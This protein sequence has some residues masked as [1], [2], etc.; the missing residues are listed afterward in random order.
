MSLQKSVMLIISVTTPTVSPPDFMGD[1]DRSVAGEQ[2]EI[3]S[4][5]VP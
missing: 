3:M 1:K 5:N 4:K 2:C